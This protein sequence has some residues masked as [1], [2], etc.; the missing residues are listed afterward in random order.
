MGRGK[1]RA[2]AAGGCDITEARDTVRGRR[3]G[4]EDRELS[5]G[6]YLRVPELLG[7]QTML[8][9]PPAH[10]ELL[11]IVIHQAYELW[12]KQ[13]LFELE[14]IRSCLFDGETRRARHY[15][16]RV[17]SIDRLL[18]EQIPILETMSPQE[19]LE[20]RHNLAPASGF[21]S[22]QFREVECVS[23]LREPGTVKRLGDLPE[24][25]ARLQRRLDEP[26]LWD[27]F[28]HVM[29]RNGFP[30]P[31][32]DPEVRRGSLLRLARDEGTY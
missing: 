25:R 6:V 27:A 23:G 4:E 31:A 12:F 32:G 29:E 17:H 2:A 24:E 5:Y 10:D 22:V 28:C 13:L 3:F 1:L 20:F 11:F 15:L 18:I 14:S 7:L 16:R 26:T 8:S 19:F 9:D 21:Q 30:M